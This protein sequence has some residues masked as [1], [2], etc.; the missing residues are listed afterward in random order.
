[1][2]NY[3][4][5]IP[6]TPRHA[7]LNSAV[8]RAEILERELG[9]MRLKVGQLRN[10]LV[11]SGPSAPEEKVAPPSVDVLPLVTRLGDT[12]DSTENHIR[13][14]EHELEVLLESV[15]Q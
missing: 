4:S 10:A 14:I 2:S 3:S 6:L 15:A 7:S 13:D 8:C 12:L 5:N 1:M 9:R 11:G